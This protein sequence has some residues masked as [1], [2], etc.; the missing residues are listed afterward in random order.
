MDAIG[1]QVGGAAVLQM[2]HDD[3]VGENAV[4]WDEY[5][6]GFDQSLLSIHLLSV[7]V[8][9]TLEVAEQELAA[10]VVI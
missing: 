9:A 7:A 1:A 6:N 2:G 10:R 8:R 4:I 3:R 5:V